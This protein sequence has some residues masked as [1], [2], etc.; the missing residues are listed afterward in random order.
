MKS[1]SSGF[2]ALY[3]E[4]QTPVDEKQTNKQESTNMV[5]KQNKLI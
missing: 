3:L 5:W 2:Q 4:T 1:I